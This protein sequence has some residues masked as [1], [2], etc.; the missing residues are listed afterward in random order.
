M[1]RAKKVVTDSEPEPSA[2]ASSVDTPVGN[3]DESFPA[4]GGSEDEADEGVQREEGDE[5][6]AMEVR[7]DS[8][9]RCPNIPMLTLMPYI[10][11]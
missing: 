7:Q 4:S 1:P 8:H 3:H 10:G 5:D 11:C 9:T 2:P 6:V